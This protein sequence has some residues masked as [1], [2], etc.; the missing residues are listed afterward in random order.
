MN[1]DQHR[2]T[3]IG[4]GHS[5]LARLA[6]RAGRP[7]WYSAATTGLLERP[8]PSQFCLVEI[9]TNAPAKATYDRQSR[10]RG[11]PLVIQ[12]P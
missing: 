12:S 2:S 4:C 3:R 1:A 6:V 8:I 11:E 7:I 9:A 10:S 5:V